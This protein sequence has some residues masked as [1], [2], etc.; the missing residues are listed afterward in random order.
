MTGKLLYLNIYIIN[1]IS[2]GGVLVDFNVFRLKESLG[3]KQKIA[4]NCS[5]SLFNRKVHSIG[6]D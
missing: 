4:A 3:M 1:G 5:P 2:V 6:M